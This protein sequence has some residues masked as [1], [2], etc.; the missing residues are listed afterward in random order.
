MKP[1]EVDK[2]FRKISLNNET[3]SYLHFNEPTEE[4]VVADK[5]IEEASASPDNLDEEACFH[6]EDVP[7]I[8]MISM[9]N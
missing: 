5:I 3:Y 7:K 2:L 9:K 8:R 6:P 1:I 4:P